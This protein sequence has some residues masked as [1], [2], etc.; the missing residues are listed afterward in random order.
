[1]DNIRVFTLAR[2]LTAIFLFL[3]PVL[4]EV[5]EL[6]FRFIFT[7]HLLA[8]IYKFCLPRDF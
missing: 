3:A 1:M 4:Y 6:F 2:H 7:E 8:N 5:T